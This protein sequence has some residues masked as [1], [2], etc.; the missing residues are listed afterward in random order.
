MISK[1]LKKPIEIIRSNLEWESKDGDIYLEDM[2]DTHIQNIIIMLYNK[3]KSCNE[4]GLGIYKYNG[5][6]SIEWI[7]VFK[8]ELKYRESL[9][10]GAPEYV[11]EEEK[12]VFL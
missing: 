7:D 8:K 5:I 12:T 9:V 2:E 10:I 6:S 1:L 4:I 11:K 3:Q